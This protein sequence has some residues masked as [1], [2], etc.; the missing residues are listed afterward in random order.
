MRHPLRIVLLC[1]FVPWVA[2]GW[3]LAC[4][5]GT[6]FADLPDA[7]QPAA[8]ARA[9]AK[10][11]VGAIGDGDL[12]NDASDAYSW[13]DC[14][15]K[16]ANVAART[17]PQIWSANYT[18]ETEVWVSGVFVTGVSAGACTAG[19]A[20]QFFVQD[21]TY[22]DLASAAKHAIK[23]FVSANTSSYFTGI[24]AGDRVDVL[25]YAWRYNLGGQNELLIQVNAK[26][27]GC[28]KKVGTGNVS[29]VTNVPLTSLTV[30][31]Y[32]NTYG[33][34]LVQVSDVSGRP[35][36]TPT[37]TFGIWPTGQFPE[38]GGP[39]QSLSPTL[40]PGA[41]FSGL[42]TDGGVARFSTVTGVF[43]VFVPPVDGGSPPKF[44]EIYPRTPGE[45]VKQ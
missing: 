2:G 31:A 23:V 12:G 30:A 45:I 38:A 36:P 13:P 28:F 7:E 33:P 34:V 9:D 17:I 5:D 10:R 6:R 35:D 3:L 19:Q 37:T 41:A 14:N 22:P 20:C 8:D 15:T 44:A 25:G 42:Y 26:L 11:D 18:T 16:P 1:A 24:R 29:A 32:E 39:Q 4:G 27:P 40:L 21:G 43:G